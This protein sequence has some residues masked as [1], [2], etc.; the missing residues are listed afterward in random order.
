MFTD[1]WGGQSNGIMFLCFLGF[2]LGLLGVAF[3][4]R[5]LCLGLGFRVV[6]LRLGVL[7]WGVGVRV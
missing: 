3:G 7:G 6:G 4:F 2:G 1:Q 5:V